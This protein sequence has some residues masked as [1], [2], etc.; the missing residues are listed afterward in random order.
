VSDDGLGC[1]LV[2]IARE[3]IAVELGVADHAADRAQRTVATQTALD[4]PGATFV[5]LFRRSMLRGCIGS[6]EARRPLGVDVRANALAAAFVDPR[7]PP[8]SAQ[9]FP[10]TRVEISLLSAPEAIANHG[11]Q[12]I[13]QALKANIDGVVLD[14]AGRRATFLPQVWESLPEPAGFIAELKRKAGLPVDFWDAGIEVSRYAVTKWREIE[15]RGDIPADAF[16]GARNAAVEAPGDALPRIPGDG[17]HT[18][19]AAS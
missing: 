3:A 7:F 17:P 18:I 4:A 15:L 10:D 19:E 13:L 2:A 5:T 12:S 1:A 8:L 9:E 14:Y 11:E 6:L 16:G